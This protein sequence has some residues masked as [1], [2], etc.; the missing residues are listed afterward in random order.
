MC[1]WYEYSIPGNIHYGYVGRA[2]GFSAFELHLGAS[3][4]EI[5]DLAHR[6]LLELLGKWFVNFHIDLGCL[7]NI[8]F[9]RYVNFEWWGT[10]FD[11]P[12][13]FAAVSLGID[14][15]DIG[16]YPSNIAYFGPFLTAYSAYLKHMPDPLYSFLNE[17]WPYPIGFF[18][19]G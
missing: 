8:E 3:Y 1:D 2:G 16:P 17:A 12:H 6:E 4:A 11:D 14:L 19:G 10:G 7:I 18:N 5:T 9:D 15:Y 13:D